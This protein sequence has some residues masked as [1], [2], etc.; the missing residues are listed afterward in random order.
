MKRNFSLLRLVMLTASLVLD[1][2]LPTAV[3]VGSV[4]WWVQCALCPGTGVVK[5]TLGFSRAAEG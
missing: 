5:D 4:A 1:P 2:L 3:W